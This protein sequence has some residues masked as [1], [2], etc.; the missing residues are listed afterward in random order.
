VVERRWRR[1]PGLLG[2]VVR[3]G[4]AWIWA[5]SGLAAAAVLG[6]A[7]VRWGGGPRLR[8][9]RPLL[10]GAEVRQDGLSGVAAGS[11]RAAASRRRRCFP[12]PWGRR[13]CG[14]WMQPWSPCGEV[15]CPCGDQRLWWTRSLGG[16]VVCGRRRGGIR[17]PLFTVM[18]Q[19][20]SFATPPPLRSVALRGRDGQRRGEIRALQRATA[21]PVGAVSSLEALAWPCPS[22]FMAPGETLG[23][24]RRARQR[25]RLGVVPF[26]EA[27]SRCP[28]CL[29]EERLE[30][31]ASL[32]L[33][34]RCGVSGCH[35]WVVAVGMSIRGA[36]T[37]SSTPHPQRLPR[38]RLAPAVHLPIF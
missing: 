22:P 31:A 18:A 4:G 16:V 13:G 11:G 24:V 35:E 23:S 10:V 8:W 33:A 36:I 3:P 20:D 14:G 29:P 17:L 5:R 37:P 6:T 21:T 30:W 26:L 1:A 19:G 25:R 12:W 34:V 2:A 28:G 15:G 9:S 7:P 32:A 27:L 38:V